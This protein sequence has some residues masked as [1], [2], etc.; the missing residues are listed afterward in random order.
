M[1]EIKRSALLMYSAAEMFKLVQDVPHYPQFLPW[2]EQA[3]VLEHSDEHMVASLHIGRNAIKYAFTTRNEFVL[4][5]AIDMKLVEG[6]FKYLK[7]RWQFLALD[8]QACK[9]DLELGFE[10]E[11][12]M[13]AAALGPVFGEIANTMVDAFHKRAKDVYGAR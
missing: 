7:G 10:F 3:D 13:M 12:R 11:S 1:T 6:P 5:E 8:E 9:I 2:C 4:N